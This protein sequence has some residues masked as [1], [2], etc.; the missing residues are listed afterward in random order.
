[1]LQNR[2]GGLAQRNPPF[3]VTEFFVVAADYAEPVIGPRV[4]RTRWLIRPAVDFAR[5][6]WLIRP[7]NFVPAIHVFFSSAFHPRERS[8][9]IA[10][11][12]Q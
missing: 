3:P 6:R 5:T 12:T 4:A 9:E 10:V 11:A 1:M 7:A 8:R 2:R